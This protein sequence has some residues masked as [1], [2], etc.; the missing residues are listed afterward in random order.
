MR[1]ISLTI[2]A[3]GSYGKK[4]SIDFSLLKQNLFLVS[5]DTGS[6]KSTLFDAIVYA[7]Y[8]EASSEQNKKSGT[9]LVSQ[10]AEPGTEPFVELEF[11]ENAGGETLIYRV[12]RIPSYYRKKDRGFG[13]KSKPE[14]EK[15]TLIMPDGSIYPSKETNKKLEEIV[16]LTKSQFMQIAMIAQGEFMDLLRAK[17]DEKKLIFRKL[18]G[19]GFYSRIVDSLAEKKK[20]KEAEIT[21]LK[22]ACQT[23][24]AHADLPKAGKSE[25]ETECFAR[26]EALKR[27]ILKQVNIA[28]VESFLE[29]LKEACLSLEEE[30][31]D[32]EKELMQAEKRLDERKAALTRGESLENAFRALA[33]AGQSLKECEEE[34]DAVREKLI[35]SGKI[36][37]S[38]ELAAVYRNVQQAKETAGKNREQQQLL[39]EQL[40][41]LEKT[42]TEA[43]EAEADC[44][45]KYES[46]SAVYAAVQ[47]KTAKAAA[48]FARIK[49]AEQADREKTAAL[50]AARKAKAVAESAMDQFEQTAASWRE[51]AQSL[52]EVPV[53]Q[54][55]WEH[56]QKEIR[57]A[58]EA[59]SEA[60]GCEKEASKGRTL[61]ERK[62][63]EY[64]E[65]VSAYRKINADYMEYSQAYLDAQA[66][67]IAASLKE[68][69]PCPVCGSKSHPDPCRLH[70]EH[71]ELTREGLEKLAE[72]VRKQNE[73]ANSRSAEAGKAGQEFRER[74]RQAEESRLKL[75]DMLAQRDES[76]RE[77]FAFK[78]AEAVISSWKQEHGSKGEKIRKQAQ[79]LGAL[80]KQLAA[81]PE[82]KERLFTAAECAREAE[83][84]AA[85]E[86]AGSE[87]AL[88]TLL[89]QRE[90]ESEEAAGEKEQ[91]QKKKLSVCRKQWTEAAQK[92]K[93]AKS[94]KEHARTLLDQYQ[95]EL[96]RQE[97]FYKEAN[98][99][100]LQQMQEKAMEEP[101]WMELAGSYP[102]SAAK[103]LQAE[104]EAWREKKDQAE[105]SRKAALAL[106]DGAE[107]P[108][109]QLLTEWKGAAEQALLEKKTSYEELNHYTRENGKVVQALEKLL[110]Q[111]GSMAEEYNRIESLHSR[112]A[113]KITGSR[114]DIETY[115]QRYYL[116]RILSAANQ[117]FFEMSAGQY[118]LR[119][120]EDGE[121]G[122][123][124]NK[125]LDLTVYSNVTGKVRGIRTLS[126][127][128]SFMA[129]LAMALGMADQI[130]ENSAA[131]NLDI[132]FI[133]EGFG[134]LDD[135][136]RNQS[137]RVLQQMAMGSRMIGIISHVTELKQEID[138][139][140]IVTKDENGSHARWQLS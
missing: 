49:E 116:R 70:E 23:E 106:I 105:G 84:K 118:E 50:S 44:R 93:E 8:G 126:G 71:R 98:G 17:S 28:A 114:M 14:T 88:Q 112:L 55:Q 12:K 69:Q 33:S 34:A 13:L 137:V 123:G 30:K 103:D 136:S 2:Q 15:V 32:A 7:L 97:A 22:T 113:G 76:F 37:A 65:A 78:Q 102:K 26:L 59:L 35:L 21:K 58:A 111:S 68:G 72:E 64:R 79:R 31:A 40:P 140:L 25:T 100:Y 47:E 127:G 43:A 108:D 46:E 20:E 139:Q 85:E 52:E 61:A 10:F 81:A 101:E 130:Q 115:V 57:E 56:E 132:M 89:E 45:Q 39:K 9:E 124:K 87:K 91:E 1:P 80:Q 110:K 53:M 36:L 41:I 38:Y 96:P 135:H 73:E 104:A 99:K 29:E 82:Q 4:T 54:L 6:G 24:A 117:H 133:D 92:Q 60:A 107:Q 131:L 63:R 18:F 77:N 19:T 83:G 42:E 95:E 5:G 90:F 122:Q 27:D 94:E 16:G 11:S 62:A 51:E 3:F 75:A 86:K 121:A 138:D 128:E 125:G 66:G 120:V 67:F 74:E 134:S 109:L 119:M 129:A 48:L